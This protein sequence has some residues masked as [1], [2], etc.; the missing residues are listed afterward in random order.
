M[1]IQKNAVKEF[2]LLLDEV[3]QL[4][5]KRKEFNDKAEQ[6]DTKS[7]EKFV[8]AVGVMRETGV[9]DYEISELTRE[10]LRNKIPKTSLN[11]Y[12]S[13]LKPETEESTSQS[14][15]NSE[16]GQNDNNNDTEEESTFEEPEPM[17]VTTGGE[18]EKV[19][20]KLESVGVDLKQQRIDELEA[21]LR[22]SEEQKEQF[23]R[24][25]L[26]RGKH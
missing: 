25:S 2:H 22:K 18:E 6:L 23:K 24:D 1:S 9:G 19:E 13:E 3:I 14:E 12:L 16:L 4:Q 8:Q 20:Q 7:R 11:R 26:A 5:S 17:V 10:Y 15:P 21:A